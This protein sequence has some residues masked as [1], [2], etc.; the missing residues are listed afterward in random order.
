MS[1]DSIPTAFLML[2]YIRRCTFHIET[3]RIFAMDTRGE[4]MLQRQI[5]K[6]KQGLADL[7]D[8]RPCSL[9][10][11]YNLC[12]SPGCRC[13]ATPPVKHGPY[14]QVSYTRKGKKQQ[15]VREKGGFACGAQT[16]QELRTHGA[17]DAALD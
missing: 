6:V 3:Y 16:A 5:E 10:T 2:S 4:A 7:G 15:Q 13:K 12:G 11:Q 14:Y 8:L 1:I 9:S 17:T